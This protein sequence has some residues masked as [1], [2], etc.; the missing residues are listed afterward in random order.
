MSE[1]G[2][3]QGV[4]DL[5]AAITA[6]QSALAARLNFLQTAT[7]YFQGLVELERAVG[8]PVITEMMQGGQAP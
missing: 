7:R 1:T 8:R 5:T 2:Y 4:L 3:K 6:Q